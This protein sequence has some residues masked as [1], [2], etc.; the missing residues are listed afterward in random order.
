MKL[1]KRSWA[2]ILV[3]SGL[4]LSELLTEVRKRQK[5]RANI[6]PSKG[7]AELHHTEGAATPPDHKQNNSHQEYPEPMSPSPEIKEVHSKSH[8]AYTYNNKKHWLDYAIFGAAFIAAIGGMAAAGLT[9]WQAWIAKDTAERQLRAY[10]ASRPDWIFE[11]NDTI[12]VRMRYTLTNHGQTPAYELT[13]TAVVEILPYPLPL[14]H[15]LPI[16]PKLSE[17]TVTVH[18]TSSVYGLTSATRTFSKSDISKAVANDGVRIYV[19]GLV[20][21]KDAFGTVRRTRFCSSVVGGKE[22]ATVATGIPSP[23][24]PILYEPCSQHN[25][26]T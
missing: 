12:P 14:N 17:S 11:F 3:V 1:S 21:Y 24:M 22:L 10:V 5:Q 8:C 7:H 15:P 26:A 2:L 13:H 4:L 16:I 23:S 9:G 20:E 19:L 6:G 25:E 18:P